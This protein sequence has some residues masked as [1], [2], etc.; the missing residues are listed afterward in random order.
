MSAPEYWSWWQGGLALGLTAVG[1]RWLSGRPMGLSGVYTRLLSFRAERAREREA[2]TLSQ[3]QEAMALALR[4]AT[5]DAFGPDAVTEVVSEGDSKARPMGP[6]VPVASLIVFVAMMAVGAFLARALNGGT[7]SLPEVT[8]HPL[9]LALWGELNVWPALLFGGLLIGF[10]TRMS[11]GCTSG[12]GLS[13]A[14]RFQPA[15]LI[16][17]ASFFGAG[18]VVSFALVGLLP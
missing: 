10:G 6:P 16:A 4:Q 14:G 15:S 5:L 1:Y 18:V 8:P 3:Q 9:Q 2:A 11:G 17:T 7:A 13:G 12:H